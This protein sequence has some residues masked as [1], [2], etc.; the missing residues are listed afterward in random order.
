MRTLF[1]QA[2]STVKIEID[3]DTLRKL[4]KR[5]AVVSTVQH[6]AAVDPVKQR[7]KELGK[8]VLNLKGSHSKLVNQVLGCT[9]FSEDQVKDLDAVLYIGSGKFHPKALAL[10]TG[11]PIHIY[12]P[13]TKSYSILEEEEVERLRKK[14]RGATVVFLSSTHIGILFTTKPGQWPMQF[15][16]K[17]MDELERKYPDKE[18]Y[19]FIDDTFD[20]S[21]LENFPFIECFVNTACPNIAY[22]EGFPRPVLNMELVLSL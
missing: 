16:L 12:N 11:K 17:R 22:D 6:L 20:L 7:L 21:R 4:P 18:F 1:I 5:L 10:R 13:L 9:A 2:R 14:E 19:L 15:T 8:Q 3:D